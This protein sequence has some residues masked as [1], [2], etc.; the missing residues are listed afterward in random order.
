[1]DDVCSYASNEIAINWNAPLVYVAAAIDTLTTK[2][3]MSHPDPALAALLRQEEALQFDS[4][5]H[6]T[7]LELGLGIVALARAKQQAVAVDITRNGSQLFYHGMEGT[8][9]DH[10]DWIR[11]KRNLVE[12]TGHSSFY[13]HTEVKNSGGDFDAIPT[14]D[15]REYAAHGGAFPLLVR[16]AGRVGTITVSGLPGPEDHAMVVQALQTYLKVELR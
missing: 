7:A 1:M 10:A 9:N 11:R 4:F 2:E 8:S 5:N 3:S 16:G 12:R 13:T 15:P 6:Q 14:L